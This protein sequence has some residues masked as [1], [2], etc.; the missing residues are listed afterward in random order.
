MNA[1]HDPTPE[2]IKAM[3]AK[4]DEAGGMRPYVT[5]RD[6]D[7]VYVMS[8]RDIRDNPEASDDRP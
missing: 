5:V 7:Y 3:E 1:L 2:Q 6:G 8:K 4:L